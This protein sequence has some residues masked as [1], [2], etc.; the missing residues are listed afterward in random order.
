VHNYNI[1]VEVI[2][3]KIEPKRIDTK[4]TREQRLQEIEKIAS[5][6]RVDLSNFKFDSQSQ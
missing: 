5:P 4:L 2:A 1:S 6:F 3:F